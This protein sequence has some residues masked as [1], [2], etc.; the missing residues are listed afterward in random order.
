PG[1]RTLAHQTPEIRDV[2]PIAIGVA[3]VV[4]P[5]AV[6]GDQDDV[7]S[8]IDRLCMKGDGRGRNRRA[9]ERERFHDAATVP[10]PSPYPTCH[11]CPALPAFPAFPAR[12]AR[13]PAVASRLLHRRMSGPRPGE[14]PGAVNRRVVDVRVRSRHAGGTRTRRSDTRIPIATANEAFLGAWPAMAARM[15][16]PLSRFAL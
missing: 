13:P 3:K 4:A 7:G 15:C 1:I 5:H 11:A 8:R 10:Q 16:L 9:D 14:S 2:Q 6:D 12:P